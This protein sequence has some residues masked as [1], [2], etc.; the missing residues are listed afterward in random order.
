[1]CRSEKKKKVLL[2]QSDLIFSSQK[3][4]GNTMFALSYKNVYGTDINLFS[5]M[6]LAEKAACCIISN[7]FCDIVDIEESNLIAECINAGN[8]REAL[9]IWRELGIP[10]EIWI[11]KVTLETEVETPHISLFTNE[12]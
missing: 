1:V 7:W 4:K 5:T 2:S 3:G 12:V 6:E 8:Y 10:E 11:Q 9:N